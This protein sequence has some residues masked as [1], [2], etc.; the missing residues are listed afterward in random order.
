MATQLHLFTTSLL[1]KPHVSRAGVYLALYSGMTALVGAAVGFCAL[2]IK[3]QVPQQ[4][5]TIWERMKLAVIGSIIGPTL[6][7]ITLLYILT[8]CET[9]PNTIEWK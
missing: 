3:K 5:Q 1:S 4:Q 6:L 2:R 8:G 7:P 9:D